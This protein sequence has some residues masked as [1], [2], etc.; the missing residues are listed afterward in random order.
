MKIVSKIE[1]E[2]FDEKKVIKR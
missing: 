1:D 2:I